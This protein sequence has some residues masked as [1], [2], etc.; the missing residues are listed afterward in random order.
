MT[1]QEIE[2]RKAT[3]TVYRNLRNARIRQPTIQ[4]LR[5]LTQYLEIKSGPDWSSRGTEILEHTL[6]IIVTNF[7]V[8][9]ANFSDRI[10][11]LLYSSSVEHQEVL[12]WKNGILTPFKELR[13]K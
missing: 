10:L 3:R 4:E 1:E 8:D 9:I 11:I 13:Y 5:D 12:Y 6:P 7:E 2:F